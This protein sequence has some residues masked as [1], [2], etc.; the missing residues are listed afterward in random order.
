M[1]SSYESTLFSHIYRE[2]NMALDWMAKYGSS[3]RFTSLT[4]FSSP[5]Y[6]DSLF[7][8]VDANLGRTLVR[9]GT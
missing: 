7:I 9:K 3:L 2:S 8:L 1:I 4:I 5:P 6:W